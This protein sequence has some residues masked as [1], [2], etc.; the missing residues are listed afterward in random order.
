MFGNSVHLTADGKYGHIYQQAQ[1]Y[2]TQHF[3][4]LPP[5]DMYYDA[6]GKIQSGENGNSI[7]V[8]IQ[9]KNFGDTIGLLFENDHIRLDSVSTSC[10]SELK[11]LYGYHE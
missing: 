4:H 1:T 11:D 5:V 6:E 3:T 9:A 7:F 2:L 10:S 8:Q